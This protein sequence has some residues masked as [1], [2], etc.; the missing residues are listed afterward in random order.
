M[1]FCKS[2]KI[3][4]RENIDFVRGYIKSFLLAIKKLKEKGYAHGDIKKKNFV[5]QNPKKY[6]LIDF[7]SVYSANTSASHSLIFP[8]IPPWKKFFAK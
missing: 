4:Y 2:K 3:N 7:D 1:P 8:F 5:Y 6:R